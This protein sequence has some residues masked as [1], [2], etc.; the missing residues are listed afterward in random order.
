MPGNWKCNYPK[1]LAE[2]AKKKC[3]NSKSGLHVL[4][5]M[6]VEVNISSWII[7]SGAT[8]YVCYSLQL[9]RS[10]R[11]LPEWELTMRIGNGATVSVK[12][13]GEAR[14]QFGA[15]Y[16]DIEKCLFYSKL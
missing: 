2:L 7:D 1:Y 10:F 14:L 13:I 12:S 9:L 15:R 8:N 5:A 6:L 16:L 11:E 4:E 3:Q